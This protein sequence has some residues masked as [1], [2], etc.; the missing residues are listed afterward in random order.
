MVFLETIIVLII[1]VGLLVFIHELGHFIA[2]KISKIK[3]EEFALGFWKKIISFKHGETLYRINLIPLGGY[4]QLLGEE[5]KINDPR[6]FSARPI[7]FRAFVLLAGV[8]MNFLLGCL[9]FYAMLARADFV[10]SVPYI[11][12]HKFFGAN[13]IVQE[14]PVVLEIDTGS[15]AE[16]ANFPTSVVIWKI[17]NTDVNSIQEFK[18]LL[19]NNAG[20]LTNIEVLDTTGNL[21]N[22]EVTLAET[23]PKLGIVYDSEP[24]QFYKI[25]Y[26]PNKFFSGVIHSINFVSYSFDSLAEIIK[27]SFR[28]KSIEPVS[29]SVTGLVGVSDLTYTLVKFRNLNELLNLSASVSISLA[30]MNILPIPLLDGG[31]LFFIILEKIRGRRLAEKYE[32]WANRAGFIFLISLTIIITLKD[33]IQFDIIQRLINKVSSIF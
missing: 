30:L 2:A 14:K 17:N 13:T 19:D 6:S 1:I 21:S 28:E 23:S 20:K 24:L 10:I 26:R 31:H 5:K 27:I 12:G 4:T 8:I 33:I 11:T 18:T 15:P 16:K 29:Q 7:R 32:K 25:D 22:I 9:I 3:V